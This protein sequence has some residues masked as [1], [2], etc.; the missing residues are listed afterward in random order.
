[1][2]SLQALARAH[3]DLST[4]DVE[5]LSMLLADWQIIADLSF[6]DLVLWLPARGRL[7]L[8]GRRPDASDHGPTA[9]VDDIVGSFIQAGQAAAARRGA[10]RGPDRPRG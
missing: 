9:F 6:A 1:M 4:E 2:P 10:A 8:L 5:W 3:T 7:R